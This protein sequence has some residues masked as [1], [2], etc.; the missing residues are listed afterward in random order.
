MA[1]IKTS[2][3]ETGKYKIATNNVTINDLQKCID[4]EEVVVLKDLLGQELA[5][6]FI[7][8]TTEDRFKYFIDN[9]I[10][11]IIKAHIFYKY[12]LQKITWETANGRVIG[13]SEGS[14]V[15]SF[16]EQMRQVEMLYNEIATN[17]SAIQ[18]HIVYNRDLYPE[19]N[20][21]I[22]DS[23]Y[24]NLGNRFELILHY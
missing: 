23:E 5:A 24:V 15:L 22:T 19:W 21:T 4:E 8:D 17:Y 6:A 18:K 3:F 13:N 9:K 12:M 1:L 11:E 14:N 7:T 2:D 10:F 16:N 20:Y